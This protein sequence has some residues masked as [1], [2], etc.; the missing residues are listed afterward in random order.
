MFEAYTD[1]MFMEDN[2][3]AQIAPGGIFAGGGPGPGGAYQSTATT[4]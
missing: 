1:L 3:T 4:R 2:S